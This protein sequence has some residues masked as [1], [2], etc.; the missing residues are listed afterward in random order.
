MTNKQGKGMP[1][2]VVPVVSKCPSCSNIDRFEVP[3]SGLRARRKGVLLKDA[4]PDLPESRLEQL[5]NH[6]CP[7]CQGKG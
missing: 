3:A 1:R 5:A 2:D 7:K 6:T 4:F